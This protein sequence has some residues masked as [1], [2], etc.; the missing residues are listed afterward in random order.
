[1]NEERQKKNKCELYLK[2]GVVIDQRRNKC[3]MDGLY[4]SFEASV[5][6]SSEECK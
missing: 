1:M 3:F 2:E 4:K 6:S 5:N